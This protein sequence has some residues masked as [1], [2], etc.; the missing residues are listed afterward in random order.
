MRMFSHGIC[1]KVQGLLKGPIN[2]IE[3]VINRC[4][5]SKENMKTGGS[6]GPSDMDSDDWKMI[7][8][9]RQ[10]K[11]KPKELCDSIAQMARKICT[12]HTGLLE[13][14]AFTASRLVPLDKN[15][16]VDGKTTVWAMQWG[17]ERSCILCIRLLF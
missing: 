10:F 8:C 5:N 2:Y 3:P 4:A 13:I 11:S 17:L 16:V 1:F 6:S 7:L 12:H 15:V 14:R 9:S